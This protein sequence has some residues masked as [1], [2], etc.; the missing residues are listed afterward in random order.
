MNWS[1]IIVLC[2]QQIFI[3]MPFEKS[4]LETPTLTC[5]CAWTKRFRWM[6]NGDR[7]KQSIWLGAVKIM[8][9]TVTHITLRLP[10]CKGQFHKDKRQSR[11]FWMAGWSV[12]TFPCSMFKFVIVSRAYNFVFFKVFLPGADVIVLVHGLIVFS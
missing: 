7:I 1:K 2:V 3:K 8:Y 12:D 4:I 11:H 5:V 10:W 6:K 9:M